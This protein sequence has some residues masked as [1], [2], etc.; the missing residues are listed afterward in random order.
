MVNPTA[1]YRSS[2]RYVRR[3]VI[4]QLVAN[5]HQKC[6]MPLGLVRQVRE[7][8]AVLVEVVRLD[9]RLVDDIQAK[10][11]AQFVPTPQSQGR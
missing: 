10:L 2:V 3:C 5:T 4:F 6:T 1:K 9:I 11:I 7:R 8:I